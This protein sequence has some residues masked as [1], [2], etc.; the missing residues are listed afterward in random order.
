MVK[1][2][3]CSSGEPRFNSQHPQ[4]S[5]QLSVT[6][7]CGTQTICKQNTHTYKISFFFKFKKEWGKRDRDREEGVER[8]REERV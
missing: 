4:G 1:S 7:I 8:R 3:G 5:S 6:H 2:T